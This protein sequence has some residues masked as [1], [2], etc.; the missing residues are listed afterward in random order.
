MISCS[1]RRASFS[2]AHTEQARRLLYDRGNAML[3]DYCDGLNRRNFLRVGTLGGLSLASFLR[4]QSAR[5]EQPKKDVNCIFIF[6]I[7]GMP[8]HDMWDPKP[9]APAEIRGD[10]KP[11]ATSM[12]GVQFTDV[13]PG[14]CKV[15]DQLAVLR[16]M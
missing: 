3:P 7:G 5:G 4:L 14:F 16:G 9:N 12:P 13:M 6:L 10:F 1:F 2:L 11:A 15:A 8:H